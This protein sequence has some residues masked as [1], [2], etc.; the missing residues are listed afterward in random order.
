MRLM[1]QTRLLNGTRQSYDYA[2][3]LGKVWIVALLFMACSSAFGQGLQDNFADR[4]TFSGPNGDLAGDNSQ[5]T[6]ETNEPRTGGKTGGHSMWISWVAPSDGVVMFRTDGSTFDTLLSAYYFNSQGDTTLD[7]LHEAARNDDSLGIEPASLIEFGALAGRRYE[8]AVDGFAGAVGKIRLRWSFIS[9]SA[10]PPIVVSVPGDRAVKQGDP[11]TLSVD[12]Q[13]SSSVQMQWRFNETDM[14]TKGPTLFIPS[15]QPENVGTYRLRV[16]VG[17]VRF[18]TTPVE[19]QINSEGQTNALAR[20]KLIDSTDSA[21]IGED[22]GGALPASGVSAKG[23]I[24]PGT[25]RSGATD[26]GVVRGFNGSQIFNTFYAT[27]DPAEPTHCGVVG[28]KSYWMIYQPP[29]NG[30][31]TLDTLGSGY[32]TVM[33]VYTYN[34]TLTGYR[35]LISLACANDSFGTNG[36]S[37]VQVPV[38]K[39]RPY[40]VVVAG[41][42]GAYGTAWLNYTL[43]ASLPPEP[44]RLTATPLPQTFAVGS[45]AQLTVPVVGSEPL[46]YSW[47]KD[48]GPLLGQNS[49]VLLFTN[50]A[51]AQTGNYTFTVTNDLGSV[52]G[53]FSVKV[54]VPPK[55][56]L[57][58]AAGG[59]LLLL[60]TVT[61]QTYY[62][63]QST[64]LSGPWKAMT[65][66]FA[67]TGDTQSY[68]VEFK[69]MRFY[70]VC[71]E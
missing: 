71:A 67:G 58:R 4:L 9:V 1:A 12:I 46:G 53:N 30:L 2:G 59:A 37:R 31:L 10:P 54:V 56:T 34:G 57:I 13:A 43:N 26:I 22:N 8:I 28:G 50:L 20:D 17:K 5:A 51:L 38:F 27:T 47:Q 18:F 42:K 16:T 23:I 70:R 63:E 6:V 64:D 52:W 21:L 60:R 25:V 62:V 3:R 24:R 66:T 29:T 41:V 40:I 15:L 68:A 61:G 48:G 39:S 49:P 55:P 69:D 33:E 36:P 11:V 19:V 44:P 65:G 7:K 14:E 32:D 45:N 35:D